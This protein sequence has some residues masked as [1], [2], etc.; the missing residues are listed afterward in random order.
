[1]LEYVKNV[2]QSKKNLS[3]N[4]SEIGYEFY[5]TPANFFLLKVTNASAACR[6][7]AENGILVKDYSKFMQLNSFLRITI[8]TPDQTDRLLLALSR[9]AKQFATGFNRNRIKNTAGDIVKSSEEAIY[10]K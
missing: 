2:D 7:L 10:T 6:I 8:G 4:L 9:M 1:M 5:I 3:S